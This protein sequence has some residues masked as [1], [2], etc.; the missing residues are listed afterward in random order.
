MPEVLV[1]WAPVLAVP[2][3]QPQIDPGA[4][5]LIRLSTIISF[6][7][8]LGVGLYGVVFIKRSYD[9]FSLL[10]RGT[11]AIVLPIEKYETTTQGSGSNTKYYYVADLSVKLK[12]GEIAT[13]PRKPIALETIKESHKRELS[14]V[15]VRANPR[16]NR[17]TEVPSGLLKIL[18]MFV[19]ISVISFFWFRRGRQ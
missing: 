17:F 14:I 19:G 1:W 10:T 11:T 5:Q 7:L 9:E 15:F 4:L 12:N 18:L 13:I 3:Q 6:I 8:I 2:P 16:I